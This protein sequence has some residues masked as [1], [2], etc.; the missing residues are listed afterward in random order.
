MQNQLISLII[1]AGLSLT[2]AGLWA[3]SLAAAYWDIQRRKRSGQ[4]VN[5]V[6]WMVVV[7]LLPFIGLIGYGLARQLSQPPQDQSREEEPPVGR[8]VTRLKK[9][10]EGRRTLDQRQA[11]GQYQFAIARGPGQ[12]M[13]FHIKQF[14]AQIGRDLDSQIRLE[15]DLAV[16]RKHA[17]IYPAQGGLWIRDLASRYGTRVNGI[18]VTEQILQQGDQIEVG[19]TTLVYQANQV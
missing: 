14:P 6:L 15:K 16:S 1:M 2:I 11:S 3:L 12:G 4:R 17:L 9:E 7:G 19:E 18:A 13:V 5:Q 8:R 10:P